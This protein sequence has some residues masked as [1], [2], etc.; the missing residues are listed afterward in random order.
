MYKHG[1]DS[2]GMMLMLNFMKIL[3]SIQKLLGRTET[4]I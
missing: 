2:G 4:Q 1:V 3:H